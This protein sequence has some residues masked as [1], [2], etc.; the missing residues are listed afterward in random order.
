MISS[1]TRFSQA[2]LQS[3]RAVPRRSRVCRPRVRT[4]LSVVT[5]KGREKRIE[6]SI[7]VFLQDLLLVTLM[8]HIRNDG[9]HGQTACSHSTCWLLGPRPKI[10]ASAVQC[11]FQPGELTSWLPCRCFA[12]IPDRPS[13]ELRWSTLR[14]FLIDSALNRP[15]LI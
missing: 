2:L 6:T 9:A 13:P 8:L 15:V 5:L 10:C 7:V 1:Y 3:P 4:G 11:H 12:L 14:I